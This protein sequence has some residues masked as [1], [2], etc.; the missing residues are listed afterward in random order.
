MSAESEVLQA[1]QRACSQDP[2]VMKVGEKLLDSWKTEKN[3]YA[4]LAVSSLSIMS[5]RVV[6]C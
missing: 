3:F 1:L 4:T 6:V 5:C 2:E